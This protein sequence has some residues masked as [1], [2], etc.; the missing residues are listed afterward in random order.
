M[1][2]C[3][4]CP[5]IKNHGGTWYCPFFELNECI[6]GEHVLPSMYN[7]NGIP[8]YIPKFIP[9]NGYKYDWRGLHNEIFTRIHFGEKPKVIAEKMD[10]DYGA[11]AN[12][13]AKYRKKDGD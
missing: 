6:H 4:K 13:V 11:L 1:M 3:V 9:I 12:Y 10:I 2:F 7:D 8:T 5:R